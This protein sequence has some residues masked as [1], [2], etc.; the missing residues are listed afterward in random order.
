MMDRGRV[1]RDRLS[2]SAKPSRGIIPEDEL[3][4]RASPGPGS[5][6]LRCMG[7]LVRVGEVGRV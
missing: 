4:D 6:S 5:V 3:A 7:L 2:Q 1:D